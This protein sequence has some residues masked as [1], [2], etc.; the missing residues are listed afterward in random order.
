MAVQWR[1]TDGAGTHNE[2]RVWLDGQPVEEATVQ[3]FGQGC[4]DKSTSEWIA[5]S[6]EKVLIGWE[7]YRQSDPIEMWI[8]D[9]AIGETPIACPGKIPADPPRSRS[10]PPP[11]R[12]A[13]RG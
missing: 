1:A 6:F 10:G 3:R 11:R 8:D 4:V 7:Q 9:V 5:P 12:C 13:K 2:F